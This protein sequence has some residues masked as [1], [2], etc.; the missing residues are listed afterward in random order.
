MKFG[1]TIMVD[2][3]AKKCNKRSCLEDA[4][5]RSGFTHLCE[6]CWEILR[7]RCIRLRQLYN[8]AEQRKLEHN[9]K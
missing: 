3:D 4:T 7:V 6:D 1:E 9:P 2:F 8:F 5:L